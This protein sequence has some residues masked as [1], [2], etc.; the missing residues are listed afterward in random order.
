MFPELDFFDRAK[1]A[2]E[3]PEEIYAKY[4]S[5]PVEI[6]N[7]PEPLPW[8]EKDSVLPDGEA[9]YFL[10]CNTGPRWVLGGVFSRPFITTKQCSGKF[11]ISCIE[12]S[13]A[14]GPSVFSKKMSFPVHHV[15]VFFDGQVNITIADE[16]KPMLITA[17]EVVCVQANT[18]F[19]LD[20]RTKYVRFY[21]YTSGDGMEALVHEAG[22]SID[23][24]SLT[25]E[26][27]PVDQVR[28]AAAL[29]KFAIKHYN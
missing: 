19:S 6:P 13:N 3:V 8:S 2:E 7:P 20:F 28:L 17:G 11:A 29:E 18:P 16:D 24:A 23:R 12:T 25:D 22:N 27:S 14:Y 21:S 15:F 5:Y 9:G 26:A 10:K 1:A 4:D